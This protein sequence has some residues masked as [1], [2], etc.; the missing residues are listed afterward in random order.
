MPQVSAQVEGGAFVMTVVAPLSELASVKGMQPV[1][2]GH[3]TALSVKYTVRGSQLSL[4]C[5]L[6]A[7]PHLPISGAMALPK[8]LP[9]TNLKSYIPAV[10]EL[11]HKVRCCEATLFELSPRQ[12]T[13]RRHLPCCRSGQLGMT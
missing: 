4:A 9:G 13:A 3:R 6:M 1:K 12:L 7:P 10:I 11:I 5:T 8:W 2:D